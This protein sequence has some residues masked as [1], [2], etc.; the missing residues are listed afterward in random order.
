MLFLLYCLIVSVHF[1]LGFWLCGLCEPI[2]SGFSLKG[3]VLRFFGWMSVCLAR[4]AMIFQI[5]GESR[6]FLYYG[7]GFETRIQNKPEKRTRLKLRLS[8]VPVISK[9]SGSGL[10]LA[11]FPYFQILKKYAIV[12]LIFVRVFCKFHDQNFQ[13]HW[14]FNESFKTNFFKLDFYKF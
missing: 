12:L 5:L 11:Y 3:K 13:N 14:N 2:F 8:S 6:L 4:L 1:F 9:F 10:I 7:L